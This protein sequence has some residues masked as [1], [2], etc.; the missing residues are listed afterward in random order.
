VSKLASYSPCRSGVL[1]FA[2]LI[3]VVGL[4]PFKNFWFTQANYI[5]IAALATLGL[6]LLTGVAGLTSFGQA[7]FVGIGAYASAMLTVHWQF[8]PWLAL[9][10]AIFLTL[11]AAFLIGAITLRLSGHYLP[12]A[13]IAWALSLYYL[14][15]NIA[16]LGKSDGIMGVA[17]LKMP[18]VVFDTAR[19]MYFVIWACVALA[20]AAALNLLNSRP[21]R[22]IRALNG[23]VAMAESCGIHTARYK[24]VVF[25]TAAFFASVAG[26]LY[27][28]QQRGVNPT[29]FNLNAGIEFLFMAVVGGAG[30]VWGAIVWAIALTLLKDQLQRHLPGLIG[31]VGNAEIILFG[32]LL[33]LLLQRAPQGIWPLF[34]KVFRL[35]M[36]DRAAR[37]EFAGPFPA[38]LAPPLQRRA[39]PARGSLLLEVS[40]M[41]R[42]FGGLVAVNDL[43]FEMRAGEVV[44]LIGPNGA[45]KSTSFNL[46]TRMLD[47]SSGSIAFM[48]GT[49]GTGKGIE[50]LSARAVARRGMART[51][52]HVRLLPGMSVLDSVLVGAYTRGRAGT[53]RSILKL[54]RT[55]EAALRAEG[56]RQIDRVGLG[57]FAY[58]EA[59]SLALGQQRIVEIA[60]ALCCDPALLL[61]DEP[62]AGLRHLE[63]KALAVLLRQLREEGVSV[64]LVE[65]D[66]DFVMGLADRIIVMEFG[67]L[68]A[69]G[70]PESIRNDPAVIQAYLGA[71]A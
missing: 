49:D 63:K 14:F 58:Q 64:L 6:T 69:Q 17:P 57:S 42:T 67:T 61:L 59:T 71:A 34:M 28:N 47:L 68:I 5:G 43:S 33:I 12:L 23:G 62:A 36:P 1:V 24:M 70:T 55:E 38:L 65:H 29:P 39:M 66:M 40:H 26:W 9:P 25:L 41:R 2:V 30:H 35:L 54:N 22:A 10:V 16:P 52:Q 4:L 20:I 3:V 51:F 45:G 18:G 11:G 8:A 60:R 37:A 27:A 13:T 44:A 15:G 31:Q 7:A 56:L 53:L 46:I 19:S 21:G 50:Q 48:P 32:A